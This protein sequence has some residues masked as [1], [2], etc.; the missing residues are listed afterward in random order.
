MLGTPRSE[1]ERPTEDHLST[2]S[3][4]LVAV[5]RELTT[6][7]AEM[8]FIVVVIESA[9]P[10]AH[11]IGKIDGFGSRGCIQSRGHVDIV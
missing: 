1:P 3:Y 9:A 7:D 2:S 4:D 11:T 8:I 5:S 10:S 6:P